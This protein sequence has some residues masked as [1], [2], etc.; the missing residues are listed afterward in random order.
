MGNLS[1]HRAGID[2]AS[3][4]PGGDAVWIDFNFGIGALQRGAGAPDILNLNAT[5]IDVLGFDGVNIVED[6]GTTLELNHNWKEGTVLKPHVHWM[7]TTAAAG[8]VV[9]Q[10]DYVLVNRTATGAVGA[11]ATTITVTQAAGGVAWAPRLAEFADIVTTGLL[12]GT[13]MHVRLFRDPTVGGDTYG[14]DAALATF[15]L[16][17]QVDTLGSRQVAVK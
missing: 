12:I 13:Q 10:L 4:L 16:H 3:F 1:A 5:S 8:N 11:A 17:V 7:P 2:A 15:G 14:A 9:W 6:V